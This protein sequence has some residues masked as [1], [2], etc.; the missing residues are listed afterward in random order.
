M[1]S[2]NY[3]FRLNYDNPTEYLGP[4]FF[5]TEKTQKFTYGLH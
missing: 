5:E 4:T 1:Y 2:I 3:L